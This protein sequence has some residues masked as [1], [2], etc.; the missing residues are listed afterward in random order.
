MNPGLPS[1]F[2]SQAKRVSAAEPEARILRDALG[3]TW[4]AA[5]IATAAESG[6][7]YL[8]RP[9]LPAL[10]PADP[11]AGMTTATPPA[12]FVG[13]GADVAQAAR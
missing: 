3:Q 5:D 4:S 1:N 9:V 11:R 13:G 10:N 7:A 6:A 2:K 12:R 8:A